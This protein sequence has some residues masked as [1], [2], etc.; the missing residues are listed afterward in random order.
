MIPNETTPQA[1]TPAIAALSEK[2]AA[3]RP[4]YVPVR[5][6]PDAEI[7]KCYLN[8][9][10]YV[11]A[12]GGEAVEGWLIWEET[13]GRWLLAIHH[14]VWRSPT[15]CLLDITPHADGEPQIVFCTGGRKW[16]RVH[17][18][19]GVCEPLAADEKVRR[20]C[21][22]T[23]ELQ[24]WAEEN[25]AAGKPV[26][27]DTRFRRLRIEQASLLVEF[28]VAPRMMARPRFESSR[29][30][31]YART[32]TTVVVGAEAD[33]QQV[34]AKKAQDRAKKKAERRRKKKR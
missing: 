21:E 23:N 25:T 19:A 13:Q 15:G 18:V 10:A 26:V 9:D 2:L 30:T 8:V 32:G 20:F 7:Q 22:V 4:Q 24:R 17:Q 14:C 31:P 34:W 3:G 27:P 33:K 1:I 5:P 12:N 6:S 16:D 28:I 29:Q 11:R